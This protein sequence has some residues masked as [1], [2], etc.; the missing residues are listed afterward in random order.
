MAFN[1]EAERAG[2]LLGP[3]KDIDDDVLSNLLS[4]SW[5]AP[6][7]VDDNYWRYPWTPVGGYI[8][9][10]RSDAVDSRRMT[11]TWT[12][13]RGMYGP[14]YAVTEGKAADSPFLRGREDWQVCQVLRNLAVRD[15]P[16]EVADKPHFS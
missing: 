10:Q 3:E 4:A 16:P 6:E 1:R 15:I 7:V 5:P 8:V 14:L 13:I 11:S 2:A 12:T 9:E